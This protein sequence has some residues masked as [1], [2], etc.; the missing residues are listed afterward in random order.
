[1]NHN[2]LLIFR[3]A[4]EQIGL[5]QDELSERTGVSQADISRIECGQGNP[6][7]G[8]LARLAYGLGME[9]SIQLISSREE[10]NHCDMK[11][12]EINLPAYLLADIEHL[13]A[14]RQKGDLLHEDVLCDEVQ[15]SISAAYQSGSISSSQARYLK[16][17]YLLYR[18]GK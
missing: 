14:I 9:L 17:K 3:H 16:N 1:M 2:S 4:R 11:Y 7:I 15:S 5:S 10:E 13:K 18:E 12:H 6:T 8:L